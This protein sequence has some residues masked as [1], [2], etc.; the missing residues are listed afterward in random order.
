MLDLGTQLRVYL[1]TTAP[2]VELE[3][4]LTKPAGDSQVRPLRARNASRPTQAWAAVAAAAVVLLLVGGMAWLLR[5]DQP[6]EPAVTSTVVPTTVTPTTV[7]PTTVTP[8]PTSTAPQSVT[9]QLVDERVTPTSIGD[10]SW[11]VFDSSS[12]D[13]LDLM[14][15]TDFGAP[16]H[17]A[18]ALPDSL[19]SSE[20]IVTSARGHLVATAGDTTL[21]QWFVEIDWSGTALVHGGESLSDRSDNGGLLHSI[22]ISSSAES[23]SVTTYL[24]TGSDEELLDVDGESYLPGVDPAVDAQLLDHLVAKYDWTS[25]QSGDVWVVTVV[26]S[27]SGE[28]VGS[29]TSTFPL[30]RP[31]P[32]ADTSLFT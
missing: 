10:A 1:D 13:V 32:D 9:P 30:Y 28:P 23:G 20:G 11:K 19:L 25:A 21:T 29:G 7:I 4:I 6:E 3:D 31:D 2:A 24:L 5:T 26:D 22:G 12:V 15:A 17:S 14:A 18:P 16:Q 27:E 8:P